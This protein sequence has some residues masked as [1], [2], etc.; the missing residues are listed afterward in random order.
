MCSVSR[1]ISNTEEGRLP[2][3]SAGDGAGCVDVESEDEHP[4]ST[5]EMAK[6]ATKKEGL[7]PNI[8]STPHLTVT[9]DPVTSDR[10]VD[11]SASL[12]TSY[13]A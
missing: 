1:I 6:A 7:L 2:V 3:L 8:R 4:S 11:D 12:L 9:T 10:C 5:Q 13:K